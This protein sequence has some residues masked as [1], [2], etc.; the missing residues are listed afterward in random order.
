MSLASSIPQREGAQRF[1][2]WY[3]G[4]KGIPHSFHRLS[5]EKGETIVRVIPEVQNG[6][7]LPMRLK[8]GDNELSSFLCVEQGV[9]FLGLGERFACL[10]RVKDAVNGSYEQQGG[11]VEKFVRTMRKA[12]KDNKPL[13]S[14]AGFHEWLGW[15]DNRGPLT[16]I[17]DYGFVQGALFANGKQKYLSPDQRNYKPLCPIVL[18]LG[19]SAWQAM[20]ASCNEE[21]LNYAGHPEDYNSRYIAGDLISS[22]GG[23]LLYFNYHPGSNTS[24]PSYSMRIGEQVPFAPQVIANWW[25]P[26]DQVLNFLTAKE[27]FNLLLNHFPA[28]ALDYVFA[29]TPYYVYMPDDKKGCWQRA[30]M[31]RQYMPPQTGGMPG[32]G[33][34]YPQG[35]QGQMPGQPFAPPG[36]PPAPQ[37]PPQ[38][39]QQFQPPM[40]QAPQAGYPPPGAPVSYGPP[41][42]SGVP[43]PAFT[44]PANPTPSFGVPPAAPAMPSVSGMGIDLSGGSGSG[45]ES[46][47][48]PPGGQVPTTGPSVQMSG[49][50]PAFPAYPG[51]PVGPAAPYQPPQAPAPQY[52][53]PAP[54]QPP[55]QQYQAP[56]PAAPQYQAPAPGQYQMP[57]PPAP[58]APAAPGMPVFTPPAGVPPLHPPAPGQPTAASSMDEARA[59]LLAA[60]PAVPGQPQ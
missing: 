48:V 40:P 23:K 29:G 32:P 27:Q 54:Y 36:Q 14:Q 37:Y 9:S 16:R 11:P 12:L 22:G 57:A 18:Q 20:L 50:Q 33:Q 60:K 44:P 1:K 19:Q 6:Q 10:T 5:G 7:E 38:V 25:R 24:F 43:A 41:T 56:Q 28:E 30:M 2:N 49:P 39:P 34:L 17:E 59:R 8:A 35:P 52:Q 51:A 42:P 45:D 53:A 21:V 26:W 13:F 31:P 55:V 3:I 58:A 46:A 47:G 4:A 15:M